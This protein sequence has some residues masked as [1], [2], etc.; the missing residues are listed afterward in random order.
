MTLFKVQ[1]LQEHRDIYVHLIKINLSNIKVTFINR[2]NN[3]AL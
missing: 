3:L 2:L 1:T